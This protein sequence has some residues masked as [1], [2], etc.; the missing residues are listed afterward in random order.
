MPR[1]KK[2]R[3][4][5]NVSKAQVV[6]EPVARGVAL[7]TGI[8]ILHGLVSVLIRLAKDVMRWT[9]KFLGDIRVQK[10][11]R[12]LRVRETVPL[13]DRRIMA[14]VEAGGQLLLVGGS[15]NSVNLLTTLEHTRDIGS[16]FSNLLRQCESRSSV[17][18]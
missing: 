2:G 4:K 17:I 11:E 7:D 9:L 1:Q 6:A 16:M 14:V 5:V 13:G 3:S 12:I 18:Q 8:S 15:A 10:R